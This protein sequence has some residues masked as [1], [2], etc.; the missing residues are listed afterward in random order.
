M[1]SDQPPYPGAA[2]T[3]GVRRLPT[4]DLTATEVAP[5]AAESKDAPP[6]APADQAA[7][8]PQESAQQTPE[9]QSGADADATQGEP[10]AR[11]QSASSGGAPPRSVGW[12]PLIGAGFFGGA[13]VAAALGM[14]ALLWTPNTGALEARLAGLEQRVRDIA[15]RPL[16]A[17]IDPRTLDELSARLAKLEAAAP[18]PAALDPALGNRMSAIEGQVKAL[19]ETV[20][21][22]GRRSDEAVATARAAR[23]RAEATAA[24][25]AELTPK[26]APSGQ[27]A[28]AR[29]ELDAL[30][31]RVAAVERREKSAASGDRAV[32]LALA[33]AMLAAA[34]ERGAPF[35]PELATVKALASD[36]KAL[37]PLEPFAGSGVPPAAALARELGELVPALAQAAGVAPREG[38][39]LE[40]LQASAEKLVR[41]RPLEEIPGTDPAAIV[42]R[43][44]AKA[45]R[46]DIAGALAELGALPAAARAPAAAWIGKAQAR[47]AAIELSRRL[48]GDALSGLSR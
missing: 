10:S 6:T 2:P 30:A 33:A 13:V 8:A 1:S 11:A 3:T 44:E 32:R 9:P 7:S 25:L 23:E 43:I 4:I 5:A 38:G 20:G 16:P 48:A 21:V 35:A 27:P 42:A 18:R 34:V 17:G 19:S 45:A 15:A 37:A 39:F 29:S 22:L 26:L 24:A 14:A 28:V 47:T 41:I 31:E 36:P 12:A 46:A 40:K